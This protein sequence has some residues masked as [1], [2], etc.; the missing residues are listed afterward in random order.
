[1]TSPGETSGNSDPLFLRAMERYGGREAVGSTLW[2]EGVETV[3][4][5]GETGELQ[6]LTPADLANDEKVEATHRWPMTHIGRADPEDLALVT[7][8]AWMRRAILPAI[9]LRITGDTTRPP[10]KLDADLKVFRVPRE[11]A[12]YAGV[13]S[14]TITEIND[15]EEQPVNRDQ[16]LAFSLRF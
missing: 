1:M 12:R 9:P 7:K 5:R 3:S 11:L 2:L 8:E 13:V 16:S 14:E 6:V 15:G 4:F 10:L